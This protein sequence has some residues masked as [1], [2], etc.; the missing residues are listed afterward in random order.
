MTVCWFGFLKFVVV[1]FRREMKIIV[2]V[3]G[4]R[5]SVYLCRVGAVQVIVEEYSSSYSIFGRN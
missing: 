3:A 1:L 2:D 4:R 5:E